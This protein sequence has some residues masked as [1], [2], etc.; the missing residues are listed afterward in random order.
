[1]PGLN[2]LLKDRATFA[3]LAGGLSSRMGS[4]KALMPFQG[5][6]LIQRIIR[7]GRVV[8]GEI[9]VV[10]NQPELYQFLGVPLTR[11]W[12]DYK[13]P[14]VGFYSALMRAKTE[15]LFLVGCDMPFICPDLLAYQLELLEAS[16]W[17][18]VIPK[19]SHGLEPLHAVYRRSACIEPVRTALSQGDRSLT[20]WFNP[21]RI[22]EVTEETLK[23]FDPGLGFFR[24]LNT[25]QEFQDSQL[26]T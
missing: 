24:N 14:L 16:D 8:A 23:G 13:G 22:G 5:E 21:D 15:F 6:A 17:D 12:L 20:R 3:V 9:L 19:H 2:N 18:A 7:S 26:N 10:T 11:D 1:M 4:D 25:L